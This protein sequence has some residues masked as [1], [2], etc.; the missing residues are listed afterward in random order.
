YYLPPDLHR[1]VGEGRAHRTWLGRPTALARA[2]AAHPEARVG[3]R[4]RTHVARMGYRLFESAWERRA[5]RTDPSWVA[6]ARVA[7][8]RFVPRPEWRR[9]GAASLGE[10][11]LDRYGAL[12]I[13]G[14]AFD[15]PVEERVGEALA[16][17][18]GA[19]IHGLGL[20][21]GDRLS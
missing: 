12:A 1:A 7:P 14:Q 15:N 8:G 19:I 3:S 2:L 20:E 4:A 18:E 13:C 5:A 21:T 17:A 9:L 11:A 6:V 10:I 16:L